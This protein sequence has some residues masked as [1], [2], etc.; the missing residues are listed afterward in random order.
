MRR[1]LPLVCAVVVVDTVLYAA[2]T[3]LLPHF[4]EV[5]DLSKSKVGVLAAAYPVGVLAASIPAGVIAARF[6]AR[7]AVLAGLVFVSAASIG[8]A[9]AGSFGV[10]LAARVA[11]GLGSS[12][13]WA[14][15]LAWLSLMTPRERRGRA[16]GTAM[17]AAVFGALLGPVVGAAG[18]VI[19]IRAAFCVVAGV[20]AAL[21]LVALRSEP[22]PRESEPLG[23]IF[24]A[25]RDRDFLHGLWLINLP[26]LFFGTLNVLAPLALD[27]RGFTAVAIGA[28][29]VAAAA[30]ESGINPWIGR[31]ADRVGP[32]VPARIAL[33][34][35]IL[36]SLGLAATAWPWLLVPL[37]LAAAVAFGSFYAPALTM[38]SHA[39]DKVGLAHG[40]GFGV[41]NAAWAVGNAVGPAA[42][43]GLAELTSDAV[44][45]LVAAGICSASLLL[46]GRA[47]PRAAAQPVGEPRG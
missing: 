19:G 45:Y 24:G 2:L 31:I 28:V 38:L 46:F 1:L 7:I 8:V 10:L 42:G 13:T 36:V 32:A 34:G 25:L 20:S 4:E 18:S 29:W 11:Q 22:S 44:P 27:D 17:A 16:M 5:Y 15:G 47:R 39:T 14:G 26:A 37:V 21:V 40:L 12:L 33:A 43:G 9:L 23:V 3:P 6:S 41:M 30:I 35:S